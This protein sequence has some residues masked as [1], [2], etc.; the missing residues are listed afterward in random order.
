MKN[1]EPFKLTTITSQTRSIKK[2][3]KVAK[4]IALLGS[5]FVFIG[6]MTACEGNPLYHETFVRGQVVGIEAS[7]VVICIGNKDGAQAGQLL[8]V[9]RV[10][11]KRAAGK[12]DVS[13]RREYIG[14]L[15]IG[16]IIDDHFA[17]AQ[18][19]SGDVMLHD[20]V[21]LKQ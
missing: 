9:Y 5:I 16:S 15:V 20:V 7:D 8:R 21:E 17:R 18:A 3:L 10:V 2:A 4:G 12:G 14:E 13:Y 6:F 11:D 19:K 1:H